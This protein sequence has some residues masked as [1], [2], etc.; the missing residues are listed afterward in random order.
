MMDRSIPWIGLT[1]RLDSLD[2]AP[3]FDLPA[4]YGWRFFRPGDLEAWSAI[5]ISAGEFD[6]PDRAAAGFRKYYP[7]DDGLSERMFFLTDGGVPFATATAWFGEGDH[8]ASEGRLHWV[9]IDQAHQRRGLSYPLVSLALERMR[10]LGHRRAYLTT[11]TASWPAIRVYRRF[12]FVPMLCAEAEIEGWR[13]VSEKT[14]IDFISDINGG[15]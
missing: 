7:T 5:E 12:G 13:I 14:G 3:R 4:E 2:G 11:Q 9:G 6:S 1:M 10:R 8:D 15:K